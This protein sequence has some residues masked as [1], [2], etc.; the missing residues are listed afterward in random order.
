MK[1]SLQD[2]LLTVY[3]EMGFLTSLLFLADRGLRKL[4]PKCGFYLYRFVKQ[5]LADCPRLSTSRGKAFSFR[6]LCAPEPLLNSLDR[7]AEVI[8]R[9]FAQGAQCLAAVKNERLVGCI[10]FVRKHFAE[11]EVRADYWLPADDSCVWDFDVFVAESERLGFLFAKLWDAF[12]P[13]LKAEGVAWTL[14]RINSFNQR[15]L[16][17]H[18]SL[19]ATDCGWAL[20]LRLGAMELLISNRAPYFHAGCRQRPAFHLVSEVE[21]RRY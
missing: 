4:N 7:P 5:P 13:L 16:A 18:R 1:R 6:L 21:R 12:D 14:S 10:W 15:S 19:G 8:A 3:R 9:R 11:D 20:F 2:R 17:S